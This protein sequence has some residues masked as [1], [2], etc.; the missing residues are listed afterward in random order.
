MFGQIFTII[1]QY[2]YEHGVNS[3]LHELLI[4]KLVV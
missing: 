1:T 2:G 4:V 3:F